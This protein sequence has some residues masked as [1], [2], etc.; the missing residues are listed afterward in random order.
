MA[1]GRLF[2]TRGPA[3][4]NALSTSDVVTANVTDTVI[5]LEVNLSNFSD[6]VMTTGV[7]LHA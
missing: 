5:I 6:K 1:G 7:R 2:Q 3:T 4:A